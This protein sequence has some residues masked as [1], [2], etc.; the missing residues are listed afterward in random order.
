MIRNPK[1]IIKKIINYSEQ[2]IDNKDVRSVEKILISK[3]IS[4]GPATAKFEKKLKI[5]L[6]QNM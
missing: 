6:G 1:V 5:I 3:S 2:S 4:Q